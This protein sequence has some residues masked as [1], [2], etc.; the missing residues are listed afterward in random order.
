MREVP[1]TKVRDILGDLLNE[2]IYRKEEVIILKRGRPVAKL[3]PFSGTRR[4][5]KTEKIPL[6]EDPMYSLI[7]AG[8]GMGHT[9]A[10][11]EMDEI[12]YGG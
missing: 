10:V 2:V 9:D 7:G 6:E 4:N 1:A 8:K 12:V 5:K 3:V 11:K